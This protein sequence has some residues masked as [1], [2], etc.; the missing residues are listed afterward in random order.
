MCVYFSRSV[1][2]KQDPTNC[3]LNKRSRY[4]LVGRSRY[5]YIHRYMYT[6]MHPYIHTQIYTE[7][8]HV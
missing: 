7:Y 5:T 6:Y 2:I 3:D 1:D 8:T 4:R